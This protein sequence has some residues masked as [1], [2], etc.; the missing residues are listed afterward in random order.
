VALVLAG[1]V[2]GI[3]WSGALSPFGFVRYPWV[4]NQD[5]TINV[6]RPGTYLVF[7]EQSGAADADLPP[8]LS[9]TVIDPNARNVP[10]ESLI[11]PGTRSAPYSYRVPPNEGRAIARFTAPREGQ[12]LL[13][14]EQLNPEATDRT[15]YQDDL[16]R[17]VAVGR[18]LAWPWLRSPLGLLALGVLPLLGGIVVLVRDQR[19]RRRHRSASRMSARPL[20]AV[21]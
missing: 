15:G 18:Q 8:M 6:S 20:E 4:R 9:I 21:R 13:S 1:I 5:R 16:P 11:A 10:V 12:Y 7:E 17:T 19:R 2:G 3:V 14:V